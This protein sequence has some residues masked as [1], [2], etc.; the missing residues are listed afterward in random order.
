MEEQ[1]ADTAE[2]YLEQ[3]SLYLTALAVA[4]SQA[5]TGAPSTAKTVDADS[6]RYVLV[7]L[8]IVLKCL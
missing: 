6:Y 5:A 1:P 7:L 2:T 4:G 8:D 3:L